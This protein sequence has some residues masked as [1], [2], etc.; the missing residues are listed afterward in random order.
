[1]AL[2]YLMKTKPPKRPINGILLLDKPQ[3]LSSNKALKKVQYLFSAKKAGHTGS[4][5]PLATGV[6]PIC[7]GEATKL[8]Q[9]LLDADKSYSV[10]AVLGQRTSTADAE[11]EIISEKPV[12]V[13]SVPA[14][15]KALDNFRG[16]I[17]QTAPSYSA[18]K[19][20][21]K[22][23]YE[24]A[25]AGIEVAPKIRRVRINELRLISFSENQLRLEVQC[26]KGT[27]IRSLVDDLGELLGCGAH[28]SELR[29]TK[30]ASY[31][32]E[33]CLSLEALEQASDPSEPAALDHFLL[34]MSSALP[35]WPTL[36]LRD[37]EIVNFQHGRALKLSISSPNTRVKVCDTKGNLLGLG[38]VVDSINLA[39]KKVFN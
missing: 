10:T 29:R 8:S 15:E 20:Q 16:E 13:L 21:G 27:Y 38:E 33:S 4:L 35:H 17:E 1:M 34:P 36:S 5:D 11:G 7:L 19:F 25:R 37:E 31:E 30:A 14:I 18:L 6:L 39:P 32:I 2:R 3:G 23:L 9:Y 28:V 24:Y 22:P 12:P 26:S